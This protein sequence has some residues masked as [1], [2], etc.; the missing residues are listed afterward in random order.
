VLARIL[1]PVFFVIL[2]L[3]CATPSGSPKE[4]DDLT[5][6]SMLADPEFQRQNLPIRTLNV[7]ALSS[8]DYSETEMRE[9]VEAASQSLREQV[10]VELKVVRYIQRKWPTKT[11]LGVH[12]ELARIRRQHPDADIVI[13]YFRYDRY[14]DACDKEKNLCII[15]MTVEARNIAMTTSDYDVLVHEFGHVL[16][17]FEPHAPR[18]VM[19]AIKSDPNHSRYFT[20]GNRRV[21]LY[22]KR[23]EFTSGHDYSAPSHSLPH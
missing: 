20:V 3:G 7:V 16:M 4:G 8:E 9:S 19:T 15:G 18:G 1:L 22:N 10:G 2:A 17:P 11:F 13:G 12:S 6:E 21:I 14:E 23:R 5:V